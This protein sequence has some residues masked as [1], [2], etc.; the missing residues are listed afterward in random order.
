[1]RVGINALDVHLWVKCDIWDQAGTP[2]HKSSATH[3]V[4]GSDS[5]GG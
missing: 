3:N 2:Y 4:P 5:F 1:M